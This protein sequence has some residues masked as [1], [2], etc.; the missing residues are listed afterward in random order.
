MKLCKR[1][2]PA[3]LAMLMLSTAAFA[4]GSIDR[5]QDVKL[6]ISYQDGGTPLAGAEFSIYLVASADENGELTT[7]DAFQQFN[8]DI[9]GKNDDAWRTLASTLE[10]YVLRDNIAPTDSGNTDAN[11]YLRFPTGNARLTPG[12]YLVLGS[13]HTQGGLR[14]DVMPFMV[15]LPTQ[16]AEKGEW[17]YDVLVSPKHDSS[18]IPDTPSTITRKVLKVWDDADNK[19]RPTE[20]IVQ[21]LRDGEVYDTVTLNDENNWRYTWSNL[22]DSYTWTVVEKECEGYTVQVEQDGITFVITNTYETD[23]PDNPTPD[24]PVPPDVTPSAPNNPSLPQTGQTW[25]PVPLL[26]MGGLSFIIVGL[27]C[28]KRKGNEA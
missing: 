26:L 19:N 12:L 7:E 15:M 11:G 20:V 6:T 9:R 5:K 28:R 4:A 3:L 22:D 25:W 24:V 23:I 13:R 2:I 8:V 21:L 10:G 16:D 17:V 18:E 27:I 14:Y 1:M